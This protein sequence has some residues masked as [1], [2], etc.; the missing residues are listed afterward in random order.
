MMQELGLEASVVGVAKHYRGLVDGI[1]IET[2]DA[3]LKASIESLGMRVFVAD[4]IMQSAKDEEAVARS[5]LK[6]AS[7]L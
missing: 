6:L 5:V 2:S 1:V 7:E 3:V 4:I